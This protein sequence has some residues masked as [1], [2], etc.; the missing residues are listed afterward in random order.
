MQVDFKDDIKKDLV[1]KF[2]NDFKLKVYVD[3]FIFIFGLF[4]DYVR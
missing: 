4:M 1:K 3:N 2:L